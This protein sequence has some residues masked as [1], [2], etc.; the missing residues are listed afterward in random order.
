MNEDV[1]HSRGGWLRRLAGAAML[2]Y[3]AAAA[4]ASL[5]AGLYAES[6]DLAPFVI[7]ASF[8]VLYGVVFL[9]LGLLVL[10]GWLGRA[11]LI[12]GAILSGVVAL[13]F[14][15]A[16]T[17]GFVEILTSLAV[18]VAAVTALFER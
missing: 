13:W 11:P 18:A 1:A 9:I 5:R 2:A 4:I 15:S 7:L 17:I 14:V 6:R 3:G 10:R 16:P 8:G 12:A